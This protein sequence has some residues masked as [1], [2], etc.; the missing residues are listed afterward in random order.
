MPKCGREAAISHL[1]STLLRS[2]LP[3][4]VQTFV[5]RDHQ[6]DAKDLLEA[7]FEQYAQVGGKPTDCGVRCDVDEWD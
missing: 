7:L 4:L 3:V 5:C 6:D 1:V 2:E